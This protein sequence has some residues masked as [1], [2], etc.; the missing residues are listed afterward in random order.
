MNFPANETKI[1]A[2]DLA[3]GK[4]SM[5]ESRFVVDVAN[6][7]LTK[8]GLSNSS[9]PD[10]ALLDNLIRALRVR[11]QFPKIKIFLV[12]ADSRFRSNQQIC[13][14]SPLLADV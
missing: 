6:I 14:R 1:K 5:L 4:Y 13:R 9:E 8:V 3:G 2:Q 11:A 7:V 12:I 10:F